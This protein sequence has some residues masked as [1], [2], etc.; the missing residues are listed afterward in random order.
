MLVEQAHRGFV[1]QRSE[2]LARWADDKGGLMQ[3]RVRASNGEELTI[4]EQSR[5]DYDLG[6]LLVNWEWEYRQFRAGRLEYIPVRAFRDD[7]GRW[8]YRVE[9]WNE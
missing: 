1:E 8:P 7:M 6:A 2:A 3:L 9:R 5:L 4:E